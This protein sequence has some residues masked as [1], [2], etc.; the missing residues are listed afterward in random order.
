[1]ICWCTP[2]QANTKMKKVND[3]IKYGENL[4]VLCNYGANYCI[5]SI[6]CGILG[7]NEIANENG[8]DLVDGLHPNE[9]GAKKLGTFNACIFKKFLDRL[10]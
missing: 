10:E 4:K 1:M 7:I 8:E 5:D 9:H 6:K 3:T 2:I